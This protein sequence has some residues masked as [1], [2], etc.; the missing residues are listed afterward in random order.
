MS[1]RFWG[2]GV[3]IALLVACLCGPLCATAKPPDLPLVVEEEYVPSSETPEGV[4]A[5]TPIQV[6]PN[7]NFN[8][9]GACPVAGSVPA[10]TTVDGEVRCSRPKV[11]VSVRRNLAA[12]LLITVHPLLG[13]VST[14]KIVDMPEDHPMSGKLDQ[15]LLPSGKWIRCESFFGGGCCFVQV[16]PCCQW[17]AWLA[18]KDGHACSFQEVWAECWK[19]VLAQLKSNLESQRNCHSQLSVW[20]D[21]TPVDLKPEECCPWMAQQARKCQQAKAPEP[22]EMPDVLTNLQKLVDAETLLQKAEKLWQRGQVGEALDCY[23]IISK[24]CPG[25]RVAQMANQARE[26]LYAVLCTGEEVLPAP[27]PEAPATPPAEWKVQLKSKLQT[28]VTM[29]FADQPIREIIEDIRT[30]HGLNIVMDGP[31]IKQSKVDLGKPITFKVE[32][33]SLRSALKLVLHQAGL[34]YVLKHEVVMIVPENKLAASTCDLGCKKPKPACIGGCVGGCVGGMVSGSCCGSLIGG[35]LGATAGACVSGTCKC[36]C[37]CSEKGCCDSK[38][39]CECKCASQ[40]GCPFKAM[41]RV[42]NQCLK[43]SMKAVADFCNP[44]TVWMSEYLRTF[45]TK[46]QTY[47]GCYTS[48]EDEGECPCPRKKGKCGSCPV[49]N[50]PGSPCTPPSK[51]DDEKP[52]ARCKPLQPCLPPVDAGLIW[53]LE[54][55]EDAAGEQKTKDLEVVTE[56]GSNKRMVEVGFG[57]DLAPTALLFFNT[58]CADVK[59]TPGDVE[60]S[61]QV[62]FGPCIWHVRC[63]KAGCW[64]ESQPTETETDDD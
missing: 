10:G 46:E 1:S 15:D 41:I 23:A 38:K 19:R 32:N 21:F 27:T 43:Q 20:Q 51:E 30:F 48:T 63:G 11:P 35:A 26:Q 57:F 49:N 8:P 16:E 47:P 5:G 6:M 17:V 33:V 59:V 45:Q 4:P 22:E 13:L 53:Y 50:C 36:C 2:A 64:C 52:E 58:T 3:G 56:D 42:H 54:K 40:G 55:L 31:A 62:K 12:C 61:W 39:C 25:S 34:T 18:G 60:M 9:I 29:S 7:P 14:E 24:L 44:M 28:P 37:C